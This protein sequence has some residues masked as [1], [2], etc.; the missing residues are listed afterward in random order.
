VKRKPDGRQAE[1]GEVPPP[2]KPRGRDWPAL[3]HEWLES[4]LPRTEFL[5]SRGINPN[6]G[7]AHGKTKHWDQAVKQA[8]EKVTSTFLASSPTA[9]AVVEA[10][11]APREAV[12]TERASV[13]AAIGRPIDDVAPGA[14]PQ[15]WQLINAWR[16]KQAVE[17]WKTADSIRAHIKL[18]LRDSLV[19]TT[20]A[21]GKTH[22]S[23]KLT[24]VQARALAGVAADI[25]RI[26]RLA[27]GLSTD[28]VGVNETQGESTIVEKNVTPAEEPV[29]TFVVEMGRSGKFVRAKPRRVS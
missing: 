20:D 8:H 6:S 29:P 15:G 25:Q 19:R 21:D 11:A 14:Q 9:A 27:L 22:L 12:A 17:D 18:I 5:R 2:R 3:F 24:P 28:N 10:A 23:T 7:L 26:Q 4:G 13:A 16:A 1:E